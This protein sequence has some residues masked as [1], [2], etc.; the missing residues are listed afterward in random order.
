MRCCSSSAGLVGDGALVAGDACGGGVD[1]V[2]VVEVGVEVFGEPASTT[3]ALP[4]TSRRREPWTLAL[5][6]NSCCWTKVGPICPALDRNET[7]T[8]PPSGVVTRGHRD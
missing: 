3:T 1:F 8:D 5:H 7:L 4:D 6:S 2:G